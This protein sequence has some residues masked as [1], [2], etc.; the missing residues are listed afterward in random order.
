MYEL[1]KQYQAD[2]KLIRNFFFIIKHSAVFNLNFYVCKLI[3]YKTCTLIWNCLEI[4]NFHIKF[5]EI[6]GKILNYYKLK[7]V[8][9]DSVINF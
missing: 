2:G 9:N 5:A 7:V 3:I 8:E 4:L 6:V 1:F